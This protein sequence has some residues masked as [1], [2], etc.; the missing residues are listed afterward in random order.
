VLTYERELWASGHARVAGVDE[1]GRGPLAG[2]VVAS[3]VVFTRDFAESALLGDLLRLTDSK[4]LSRPLRESFS[5]LL[6]EAR[7]VDVGIGIADV[8]EIDEINILKATHVAMR[9]AVEALPSSPDHIIVDGLPVRGLPQPSTAIVRGDSKSLS[10]AAASVIAKVHRDQ[11]MLDLAAR[12]PSYG[13]ENHKGYGTK[14]HIRALL[15]KGP[16]PAH[17]RSF[18]P[19]RE[20][21]E[22]LRRRDGPSASPPPLGNSQLEMF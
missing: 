4:K 20:A 7:E 14:E 2:P 1:A 17:R 11:I 9:R 5:V 10:I 22:L 13:F 16:S 6:M 18:R 8:A 12:Y 21:A 3:A 15:E 19:V